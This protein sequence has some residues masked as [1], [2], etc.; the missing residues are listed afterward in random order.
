MN[1]SDK[2]RKSLSKRKEF[3]SFIVYISIGFFVMLID[4]GLFR[5]FLIQNLYRPIAASIAYL[6]AIT[7]HFFLNKFF[8]FK[9]FDRST[10]KQMQ[11][12]AIVAA[13]CW[14]ATVSV[15]EIGVRVFGLGEMFSKFVAILVNIPLS[16]LGHRYFT[17]SSGIRGGLGELKRY[18]RKR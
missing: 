1:K 8:N 11:T 18:L 14:L 4:L 6:T 15:I 17:F 9:N 12:Y 16:Y 13:F 7:V 10:F 2:K 5:L 3:I